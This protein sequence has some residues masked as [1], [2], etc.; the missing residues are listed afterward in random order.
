MRRLAAIRERATDGERLAAAVGA[1]ALRRQLP[2]P[3]VKA[4]EEIHGTLDDDRLGELAIAMYGSESLSA[5]KDELEEARL[6]PPVQWAGSQ[7]ALRFVRDLG[8]PPEYAGVRGATREPLLRVDGPTELPDL[9]PYQR[10]IAEGVRELLA[11]SENRRAL[12][13]LPTG[14]GKTRVAVQAI[15]EAIREDG[16]R[17]LVLWVADRDELCEQAVQ[18]W[19]EVWH[20]LGADGRLHISRHWGPN[21][22]TPMDGELQI[23]VATIQKL[24]GTVGDSDYEWLSQAECVVIDEAHG[25][26]GPQHTELLQWV[27]L[28]RSQARDRATLLGLTATPY[29]G[30]SEDE[31]QRLISRYGGRRLDLEALGT[32]PERALQEMGVLS[33]V[34]HELLPGDEVT[35]TAEEL[36]HLRR[37]RQLPPGV[38]VRLGASVSRNVKLLESI[39]RLPRDWPVLFFATSVGHAQTMAALL[40]LEGISAAAVSANTSPASRR[41][42][43]ERF[44]SGEIQVLTNYGVLTQGFDAPSTRAVYIARPTYSPNLYQQMIGRGLRGPLNGGEDRCL[45]VNVEDNVRQYGEALAFNAFDHLWKAS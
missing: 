41:F 12:I 21:D 23:V 10:T 5:L 28:G 20:S 8:F 34:D 27:G 13:A 9:H 32:E 6:S 1:D 4:V 7:A 35:L 18:S 19:S 11:R 36:D 15:V 2:D 39:K 33:H 24:Q 38:E 40:T 26:I 37:L 31:T 43:I 29:R 14:A 16:F 45:I 44:R 30:V 17:G 22:A 3:L 25:S 42:Y